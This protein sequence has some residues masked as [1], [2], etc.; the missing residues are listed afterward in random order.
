LTVGSKSWLNEKAVDGKGL[1]KKGEQGW[2]GNKG[3]DSR[4]PNPAAAVWPA[5]FKI[6]LHASGCHADFLRNK[7][8]KFS[9]RLTKESAWAEGFHSQGAG[10][11]LLNNHAGYSALCCG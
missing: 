1:F 2:A 8:K 6:T 5:V 4:S 3:A 7:S 10:R 11:G 9:G